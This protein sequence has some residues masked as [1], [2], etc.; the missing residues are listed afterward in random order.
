MVS[1]NFFRHTREL[2]ILIFIAFL[3]LDFQENTTFSKICQK[4]SETTPTAQSSGGFAPKTLPQ[5]QNIEGQVCLI[6]PIFGGNAPLPPLFP[7]L[8]LSPAKKGP[9]GTKFKPI[10][11]IFYRNCAKRVVLTI[12]GEIFAKN[13]SLEMQIK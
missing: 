13:S 12:F 6:G 2:S 11:N 8:M 5:S 4:F 7:P 3:I 9:L 1:G 10:T